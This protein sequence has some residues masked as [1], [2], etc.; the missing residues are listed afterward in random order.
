MNR[1][2]LNIR[3]DLFRVAKTAFKFIE[4]AKLE[5]DRIPVESATLKNDL[6]SY[7]AE[8]NTIQNDPL[9]RIRWGEKIITISTRLG[10]V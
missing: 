8:M 4:K 10:I 3:T 6:V 5:L 9:K 2:K 1:A 7:Q